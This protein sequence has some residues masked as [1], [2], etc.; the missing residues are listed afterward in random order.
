MR[1]DAGAVRQMLPLP[2]PAAAGTVKSLGVYL[3]AQ[4]VD[5]FV[6]LA[7][8]RVVP[9]FLPVQQ[10]AAIGLAGCL[11]NRFHLPDVKR[12]QVDAAI[13]RKSSNAQVLFSGVVH[14]R[15]GSAAIVDEYFHDRLVE[16]DV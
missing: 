15:D 8:V 3:P 2:T 11:P 14:S 10:V 5:R 16:K 12:F 1:P 6:L 4:L 9:C 13:L 7:A